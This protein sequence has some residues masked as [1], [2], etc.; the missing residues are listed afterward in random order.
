MV[1]I[2]SLSTCRPNAKLDNRQRRRH[3]QQHRRHPQQ[4]RRHPQQHRPG[5]RE[6][7]RHVQSIAEGEQVRW[8]MTSA[9]GLHSSCMAGVVCLRV[10]GCQDCQRDVSL[11]SSRRCK[12]RTP[13]ALID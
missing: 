6:G 10:L 3:P 9:T 11:P 1:K 7:Q 5:W 8:T 2:M 4:H 12:W 13:D